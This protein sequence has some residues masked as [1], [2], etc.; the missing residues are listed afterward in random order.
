MPASTSPALSYSETL[1]CSPL[2]ISLARPFERFRFGAKIFCPRHSFEIPAIRRRGQ[3]VIIGDPVG[4]LLP[5]GGRHD[6]GH[7]RHVSGKSAAHGPMSDNPAT[8]GFTTI[9]LALP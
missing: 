1:W 9:A 7:S 6:V 5:Y 2:S 3:P 4:H 8:T